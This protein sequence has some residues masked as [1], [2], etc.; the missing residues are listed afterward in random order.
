M[1]IQN[2]AQAVN[3]LF[4]THG[5][6]LPYEDTFISFPNRKSNKTIL[7]IKDVDITVP[8]AISIILSF[9]FLWTDPGGTHR[10]LVA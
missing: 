8:K 3:S 9:L 7:I 2:R 5:M 4:P 1:Y 6:L 10:S